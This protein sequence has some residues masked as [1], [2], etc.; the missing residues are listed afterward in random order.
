MRFTDYLKNY[1]KKESS[2]HLF[3]GIVFTFFISSSLRLMYL[4]CCDISSYFI[5]LI[6]SIE[7]VLGL[8]MSVM[9]LGIGYNEFISR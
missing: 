1:F 8:L 2:Y 9:A 7:K 3:V 5:E 6:P 4:Y